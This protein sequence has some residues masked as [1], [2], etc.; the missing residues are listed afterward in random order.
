MV[1]LPEHHPLCF[2][3]KPY[4]VYT[5]GRLSAF[6]TGSLPSVHRNLKP[7]KSEYNFLKLKQTVSLLK[8]HASHENI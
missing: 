5:G 2:Q 4:L 1:L 7:I 3:L 8:K 6:R